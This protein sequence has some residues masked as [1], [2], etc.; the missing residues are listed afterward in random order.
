MIERFRNYPF[1]W[2]VQEKASTYEAPVRKSFMKHQPR[3]IKSIEIKP[4]KEVKLKKFDF[5]NR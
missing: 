2:S 4:K 1:P 3:L 5:F